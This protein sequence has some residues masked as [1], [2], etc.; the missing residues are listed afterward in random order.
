[1][2][3]TLSTS[4]SLV[5]LHVVP[6]YQV[7]FRLW[8][9]TP[10]STI[11]QLCRSGQFYWWRKQEKTTDLSQ[12]TDKLYH[13]MLY[14]VHLAINRVQTYCTGSCKSNY[15]TI[16]SVPYY[17]IFTC[18]FKLFF[19]HALGIRQVL[20]TRVGGT[21]WMPYTS[22]AIGF[23]FKGYLVIKTTFIQTKSCSCVIQLFVR[24]LTVI[25]VKSPKCSIHRC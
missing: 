20:P 2:N 18:W 17:T 23:F 12:V 8:C 1:M 5:M 4:F 10:F 13:L 19:I 3:Q 15:H 7:W 22:R 21:R 14:R 6:F 16:K 24:P 9:L 11:F 25:F